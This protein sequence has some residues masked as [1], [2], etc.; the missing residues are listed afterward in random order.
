MCAARDDQAEL[1][2]LGLK[3]AEEVIS[4]VVTFFVLCLEATTKYFN[5][6]TALR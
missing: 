1:A 4:I 3:A 2:G 5:G 6:E